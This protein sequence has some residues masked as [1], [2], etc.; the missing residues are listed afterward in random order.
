MK[1]NKNFFVVG[2]KVDFIY[3]CLFD[4]W[5]SPCSII[6]IV[7]ERKIDSLVCFFFYLLWAYMFLFLETLYLFCPSHILASTD[8]WLIAS[9]PPFPLVYLNPVLIQFNFW[10]LLPLKLQFYH[11]WASKSADWLSLRIIYSTEKGFRFIERIQLQNEHIWT[12][13]MSSSLMSF[14]VAKL[15]KG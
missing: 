5:Y 1:K 15:V 9:M 7:L 2:I 6:D 13:M 3:F 4:W 8:T 14:P 10:I 11:P 12:E